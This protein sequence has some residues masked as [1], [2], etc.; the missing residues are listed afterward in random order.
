MNSKDWIN[1]V[2]AVV[3]FFVF[4]GFLFLQYSVDG[5]QLR[6]IKTSQQGG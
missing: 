3:Q 2:V 4:K 6:T 5:F 1:S